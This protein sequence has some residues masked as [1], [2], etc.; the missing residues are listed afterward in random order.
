[1]EQPPEASLVDKHAGGSAKGAPAAVAG[2]SS[3][4][5]RQEDDA[6][7]ADG[8]VETVGEGAAVQRRRPPVA[9]VFSS[10]RV[11]QIQPLQA[12]DDVQL[13]PG[14]LL[15]Q[16]EVSAVSAGT[17]MLAYRGRMPADIPTD[18]VLAG[19]SGEQTSKPFSYP[20]RF[21]Y[22]TV[23][24]IR[25]V[26]PPPVAGGG[27]K[28]RREESA[29]LQKGVRVFMFREHASWA[30]V[31]A[32]DVMRVPDDVCARDAAFLPS[33]ETALSL[34]MDVAP[35]PG[36]NVAVVGQGI[37]GLLLVTVLKMCYGWTR[38]IAIDTRADRLV[39]S[40]TCAS[41]DAAIPVRAD[42]APG[43]QFEPAL[44]RALAGGDRQGVDVAVDVSGTGEGLDTAIRATRDGGRVVIGSWFGS[45][46][47]SLSSLGGRFHRSHISLVASQVSAIPAHLT[48]RWNKERRFRL[49][50][51]ML[52][53]I[54]PSTRYPVSLVPVATAPKAYDE[55][56]RGKHLQVLFTY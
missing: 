24:V 22:A 13:A 38:V 34:A 16:A 37:V 39:A 10:P 42:L 25:R 12:M 31:G 11:V 19:E 30:V 2:A 7:L 48:A 28:R 45:R 50:W 26:G 40:R 43:S 27:T 20:A 46:E 4:P 55:V 52:P 15:V 1:M 53:S 49:A 8:V 18:A 14:Q 17:E 56:D 47:V 5:S 41:A 23:G 9:V 51:S 35:L 33:V 6:A 32:E 29:A 21:G 3:S 44:R 36:E 54:A